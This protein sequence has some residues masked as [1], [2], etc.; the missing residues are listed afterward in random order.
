MSPSAS[1]SVAAL[2]YALNADCPAV[3]E[4][5]ILELL[6]V[7]AGM[8]NVVRLPLD[9]SDWP[10]L[11]YYCER[12]ALKV[13]RSTFKLAVVRTTPLGDCFTTYVP[14]DDPLGRG[15]VAYVARSSETARSAEVVDGAGDNQEIGML[16]QY[17]RCCTDGYMEIQGGT[18]W[19][20]CITRRSNGSNQCAYANKLA[21]LFDGA[22]LF[23]D[24]FPCSLSC[25]QTS[26]QGRSYFRLLHKYGLDQL[27]E[28]LQ[29]RM[30]RPIIVGR[31]MAYQLHPAAIN[32]TYIQLNQGGVRRY[33][34]V[35]DAQDSLRDDCP[36]T[37]QHEGKWIAAYQAEI[38]L[39]TL[40]LFT[41]GP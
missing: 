17:P 4:R 10:T 35:A 9:E 41:A 6:G 5:N 3:A 37:L 8:K 34:L 12:L 19:V 23:P 33:T 7:I 29:E 20:D 36:V 26:L 11:T 13:A 16:F 24:Y 22:S 39:G 14:W 40:F 1:S 18:P 27:A 31:G 30:S 28:S 15:F 25:D 38:R 21:Y 32:D 2:L